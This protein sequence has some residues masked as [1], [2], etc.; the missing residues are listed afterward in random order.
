MLGLTQVLQGPQQ[1]KFL[2]NLIQGLAGSKCAAAQ[3]QLACRRAAA[4]DGGG[5]SL[6]QAAPAPT[7]S[8]AIGGLTV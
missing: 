1:V 2:A 7:G 6:L 8:S 3:V 5:R 4:G